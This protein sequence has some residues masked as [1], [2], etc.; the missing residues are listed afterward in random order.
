MISSP[1]AEAAE[2]HWLSEA[3][4]LEVRHEACPLF[5]PRYGGK[6]SSRQAVKGGV[7]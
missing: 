7:E 6:L 4:H 5:A 2:Y 3:P 1:S